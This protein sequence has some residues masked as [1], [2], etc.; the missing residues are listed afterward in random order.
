[1]KTLTVQ[2]PDG[3]LA[4]TGS[5]EA[6]LVDETQKLLALK[7][8]ELGRLTSGQAAEMCSMNR[9]DFLVEA[10]RA[11][12]AAVDL[13]GQELAEEVQHAGRP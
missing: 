8:F 5:S 3:L 2:V 12:V 1:M 9:V 13:D 7:F 10:G 4:H 11:G 6:A